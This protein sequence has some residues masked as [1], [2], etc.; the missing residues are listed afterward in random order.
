MTLNELLAKL[1]PELQAIGKQYGESVIA[2]GIADAQKWLEYV[3]VGRYT[4][5]Y[6]LFLKTSSVDGLLNEWDKVNT[7]WQSAN[8][9]NKAKI[10]LSQEIALAICKAMV[11]LVLALVGL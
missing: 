2:M 10:E 3:F 1:P 5:A 6:A 8:V 9:E 7:E 4:D 11:T